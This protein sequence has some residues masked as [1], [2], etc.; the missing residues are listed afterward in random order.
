[1]QL[2]ITYFPRVYI[3]ILKVRISDLGCSDS[4]ANKKVSD[5]INFAFRHD[6][7][8][9]PTRVKTFVHDVKL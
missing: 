4:E 8:L 1:M 2:N 9:V 6:I 3:I 5:V 7:N